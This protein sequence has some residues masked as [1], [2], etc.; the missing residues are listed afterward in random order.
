MNE[1]F[2]TDVKTLR[3]R[4]RASIEQG[5]ITNAY[6]ADGTRVV[7]VL[8]EEHADDLLNFLQNT[9]G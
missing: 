2:L 9:Q 3:E 7:E 1:P 8:E 4:A 5:P 6:G